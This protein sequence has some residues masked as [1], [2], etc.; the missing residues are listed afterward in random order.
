[1]EHVEKPAQSVV[2]T[3][4]PQ[5]LE[6][7]QEPAPVL[8]PASEPAQAEAQPRRAHK[9]KSE[10]REASLQAETELLRAVHAAINR[11][12]G[13]G[14]LELLHSYD[15]RFDHGLL[16]EEKSAASVLALCVSGRAERARVEAQRFVQRYPHSPLT[17]RL[18]TSCVAG[19]LK[20]EP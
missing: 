4:E 12:D 20:A 17:A 14:A 15:R 6:P 13:A 5:A 3:P 16:R 1:V 11:G 8:E 18:Q 7:V 2:A 19:A 9:R 10:K